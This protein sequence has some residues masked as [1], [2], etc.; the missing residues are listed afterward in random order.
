MFLTHIDE[1]GNDTP[2]DP[3]PE[4]HGGQ[5]RRQHPRVRELGATRRS[6]RSTCR[7]WST[8]A[9]SRTAWSS[10]AEGR[11]EEAVAAF[12]EAL[13][14][15]PE[16]QPR[17][18][19]PRLLAP[20]AGAGRG[21]AAALEAGRTRGA[22]TRRRRTTTWASRWSGTAGANGPSAIC[23]GPSS[24]T[25]S[26]RRRGTTWGSPCSAGARRV[27]R[28]PPSPK[29]CGSIPGTRGY[30][31]DFG[32]VLGQDRATDRRDP[33]VPGRRE[34]R[35]GPPPGA[36]EPRVRPAVARQPGTAPSS[37]TRRHSPWIRRAPA[38]TA[39]WPPSSCDR[40]RSPRPLA[41]LERRWWSRRTTGDPP[42]ARLAARHAS[43]TPRCA[44]GR[45]PSSWRSGARR[46]RVPGRA[47]ARHPRRG[48]R[49]DGSLRGGGR[50]G[51]ARRPARAGGRG[52]ARARSR[53]APGRATRRSAPTG[54][55]SGARRDARRRR[56]HA[57][58]LT[59]PRPRRSHSMQIRSGPGA[60]P[61]SP[62]ARRPRSAGLRR[63][64]DAAR[65][66]RW[67]RRRCSRAWRRRTRSG[68]RTRR[69]P[70]P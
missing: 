67:T 60:R 20:G 35:P 51:E 12:E 2:A 1:D 26:I 23:A 53:G 39:A 69:W 15:E 46:V 42:H 25:A 33:R 49:R 61:R 3:D 47:A 62:P 38:P 45:G 37:S 64:G 13:E 54:S 68:T 18:R 8:T 56:R 30:R 63:R 34:T 4:L 57:A 28:W 24:W 22:R 11:H 7:P 10:S 65:R 59:E 36:P 58:R 40:V 17:P 43:R 55:P 41:H 14:E 16:L 50:D 66:S 9:T 70:A 32:F 27:R 5:P 48:V 19:H 29:P 21:G 44:T 52:T 31:N 6:T